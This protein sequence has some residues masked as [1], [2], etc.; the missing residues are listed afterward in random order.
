MRLTVRTLLAW[1]DDVLGP[2]EHGELAHKVAASPVARPLVERIQAAVA[3]PAISAPAAAGRGLADDPNTAAEFLDNVLDADRLAAFERVCIESD[4]HLADVA[5][6]HRV[7]AELHR[8]AAALEPF[9]DA[10]GLAALAAA[11]A[12]QSAEAGPLIDLS[13]PRDRAPPRAAA[14][15]PGGRRGTS[16]LAWVSA[17]VALLLL[18]TA[19]L[20][21]AL[22]P[23]ALQEQVPASVRARL[24][25]IPAFFGA[26]DPLAQ[27]VNDDNFAVVERVAHWVAALRMFEQAPWLGVGA[28]SYA[29]AYP[30]VRIPRWE[31]AL[32][33]A[34]NTY[35]NTLAE[36]GLVGAGVVALL[37][38]TLALWLRRALRR[39]TLAAASGPA[40]GA[41]SGSG[42][43]AGSGS[44]LGAGPASGSG[45]AGREPQASGATFPSLPALAPALALSPAAAREQ[46][47]LVVGTLAVLVH[48]AV[49]SIVDNLFVQGIYVALALW[50]ALVAV[51]SLPLPRGPQQ[52]R[53]RP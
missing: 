5:G 9:P 11:R 3:S 22:S 40:A 8:D 41:A 14:V 34:H 1:I 35:L 32:G 47:A 4:L 39:A 16:W 42:P 37:W 36:V 26:G 50:P 31:E 7:L 6:C 24:A 38:G 15:E 2:V 13:T 52:A 44:A 28:G 29:A 51:H 48:L 21:G 43:A 12:A 53:N 49:H 46:R 10:R 17:A 33:H 20:V 25:E 45:P 18:G 27:E 30:Q 23:A 19:L